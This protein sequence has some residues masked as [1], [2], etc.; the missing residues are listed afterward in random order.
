[1]LTSLN[2][3]RLTIS[4]RYEHEYNFVGNLVKL[5]MIIT[6]VKWFIA[7]V[8]FV[9]VGVDNDDGAIGR[10]SKTK[11]ER[12]CQLSFGDMKIQSTRDQMNDLVIRKVRH[13][14]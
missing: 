7:L 13:T 14:A 1:M 4:R 3:R 5:D 2:E 6:A 11:H 8:I 9:I 10:K 12:T